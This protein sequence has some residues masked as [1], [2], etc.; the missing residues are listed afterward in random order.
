MPCKRFECFEHENNTIL[1]LLQPYSPDL[2]PCD[3]FLPRTEKIHEKT[4]IYHDLEIIPKS[5][6]QNCFENSKRRWRKYIYQRY[7]FLRVQNKYSLMNTFFWEKSKKNHLFFN[8]RLYE[9]RL[10]ISGRVD[11]CDLSSI[12]NLIILRICERIKRL[13]V[14]RQ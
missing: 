14:D 11:R 8:T 5:T 2:V 4:M 12:N 3:L 10:I 7:Y 9:L 1:M 6:N 13:I